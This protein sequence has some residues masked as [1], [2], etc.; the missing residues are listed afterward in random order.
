MKR[1]DADDLTTRQAVLIP[2]R[3]IEGKGLNGGFLFDTNA[4]SFAVSTL[5]CQYAR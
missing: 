1:A 3:D 5:I 2:L 4:M